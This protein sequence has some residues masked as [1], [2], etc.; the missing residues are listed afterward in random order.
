M[1][2]HE[3]IWGV[4]NMFQISILVVVTL[5]YFSKL[6]KLHYGEGLVLY[7]IYIFLKKKIVNSAFKWR[8]HKCNCTL[9][10]SNKKKSAWFS[11]N[12]GWEIHKNG[13]ERLTC[14][15]SLGECHISFLCVRDV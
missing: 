5:L 8:V 4:M 9:M 3:G 6:T 11:E 12:V 2:A 1:K 15:S 10:T 13:A 14:M 7:V